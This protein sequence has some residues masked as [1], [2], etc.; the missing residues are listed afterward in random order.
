VHGA[1]REA[2]RVLLPFA[3]RDLRRSFTGRR[4]P[5]ESGLLDM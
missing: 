3:G 4:L 1:H 2:L 5:G